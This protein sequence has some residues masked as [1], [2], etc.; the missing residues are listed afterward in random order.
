MLMRLLLLL[1]VCLFLAS[2]VFYLFS[3]QE[4]GT[5]YRMFHVKAKNFLDFLLPVVLG[6]FF[7]GLLAGG[8]ISL[9]FPKRIAGPLHR[10]ER[11]LDLIG[12][13]DLTVFIVLRKGD[14]MKSLAEGINR[15]VVRTRERISSLQDTLE[16]AR[17][18]IPT[19]GG[20]GERLEEIR[21]L[22]DSLF[23]ELRQFRVSND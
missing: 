22:H 23:R 3:N 5:S 13:G 10:I 1:L 7:A 8:A 2:L 19:D 15:M 18:L 12:T 6:A 20:E 21:R 14:E 9:F 16:K 11:E 4:V 17:K